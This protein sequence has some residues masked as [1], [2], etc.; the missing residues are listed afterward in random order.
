MVLDM[1][2]RRRESD[3][4]RRYRPGMTGSDIQRGY[5]FRVIGP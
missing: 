5:T 4:S 3:G 1:Y 2:Q